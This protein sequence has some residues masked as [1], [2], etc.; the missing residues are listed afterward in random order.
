MI[1]LSALFLFG[2]ATLAVGG[3]T[4]LGTNVSGS[5]VCEGPQGVCAPSSSIDD[6]ALAEIA[7]SEG[8]DQLTPAGPYP[9]DE[10]MGRSVG[11]VLAAA[12]PATSAPV[13]TADSRYTLKVVFPAY[14]DAAG[15]LHERASVDTSVQLPG[16]GDAVT[17]LAQRGSGSGRQGLL[18]AAERAPSLLALAAPS[19]APAAVAAESAAAQPTGET[20][21]TADPVSRIREQV[22]TALNAQAPRRQAAS[23]PATPE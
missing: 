18:A 9:I 11:P 20:V 21:A 15:Q 14:V 13:Q 12:A 10:G 5:F 2:C 1:R 22:Q 6:G 7:R 23:F 19:A 4:T 17:S 8:P 3:C 16:Y